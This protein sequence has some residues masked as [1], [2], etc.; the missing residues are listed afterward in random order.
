MSS[1]FTFGAELPVG[2]PLIGA[3]MRMPVD[4]VRAR[5]LAGL[6]NA[7]FTDVVAAHFSVLR[8]PGPDDRRPSDLAAEAHMTRQAMNYLLGQ[9]EQLGYLTRDADPD[10]HRSRRIHLTERGHAARRTM[11]D[12]VGQIEAEWEH[13]LGPARF[14]QL[15]RLL[16]QIN[17]THIVREFGPIQPSAAG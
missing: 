17:T 16:I 10:D 11:R 5:M 3:L 4:A 9:L 1:D 6:H 12:T 15:R 7:G 14:A 2:P 8:Y 13:E